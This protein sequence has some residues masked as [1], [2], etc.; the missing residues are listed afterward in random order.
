VGTLGALGCLYLARSTHST[1][2]LALAYAQ[3]P[4]E[5]A[6]YTVS[7]ETRLSYAAVYFGLAAFLAIM[8]EQLHAELPHPQR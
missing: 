5:K 2:L 7:A 3:T 8:C 6:Y 1:L 4:Q